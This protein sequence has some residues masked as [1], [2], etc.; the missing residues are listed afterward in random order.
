MNQS[1]TQGSSCPAETEGWMPKPQGQSPWSASCSNLA[2][3][4]HGFA[5]T[6]AQQR[7]PARELDIPPGRVPPR[8][9]RRGGAAHYHSVGKEQHRG[10]FDPF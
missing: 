9:D 10:T 3:I 7:W 1:T 5:P 4:S 8:D 2:D 6:S